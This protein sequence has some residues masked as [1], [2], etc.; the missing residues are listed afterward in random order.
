MPTNKEKIAKVIDALKKEAQAS[1]TTETKKTESAESLF[2]SELL[3]TASVEPKVDAKNIAQ[4]IINHLQKEQEE[5][6]MAE[7]TAGVSALGAVA[8]APGVDAPG[9]DEP[10]LGKTVT[11]TNE[12]EKGHVAK[13]V[14]EKVN[15]LINQLVA[16][17]GVGGSVIT[18]EQTN[19]LMPAMGKQSELEKEAAEKRG[20]A[21]EVLK[22]LF[23]KFATVE[24]EAAQA[25]AVSVLE[26]YASMAEDWIIESGIKE[27]EYDHTHIQKVAETFI[28]RDL[29][30]E[31]EQEMSKQ[32]AY[33]FG[34][35]VADAFYARLEDLGNAELNK[36]AEVENATAEAKK[37]LDK[38]ASGQYTDEDVQRVA[39]FLLSQRNE[40][41]PADA[42]INELTQKV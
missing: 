14:T 20:A 11:T 27:G 8:S 40:V 39:E 34:S 32:A 19:A 23:E 7:K 28:S 12:I 17:Y 15:A 9:P 33:E 31:Q 26:K 35:N 24:G 21:G 25:E 38:K 18:D 1:E 3:K 30:V 5:N 4:E 2:S 42:V 29:A 37:L 22:N 41:N 10:S 6:D 36:Q 13:E 16:T